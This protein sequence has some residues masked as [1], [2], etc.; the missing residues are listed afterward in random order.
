MK[1]IDISMM[2]DASY[3]MHKPVGVKPLMLEIE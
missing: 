3:D 2:V 1:V